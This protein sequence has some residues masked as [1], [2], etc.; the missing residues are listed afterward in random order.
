MGKKYRI[1]SK[2]RFTLFLVIAFLCIFTALTS[3]LGFNNAGGSSMDEYHAIK[4][5]AGDTLWNIAAEYGPEN[6]DIRKTVYEICELNEMNASELEAGQRIL[7]PAY[8]Q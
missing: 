1:R 5:S 3:L 7:V 2:F 4:I 6:Q 8:E